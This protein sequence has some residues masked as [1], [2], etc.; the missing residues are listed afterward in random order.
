[1]KH[2]LV[3]TALC[4]AAFPAHAQVQVKDPWVRA[5]V[6]QQ[7]SSGAFMQI[8]SPAELRLVSVSSPVAGVVELHRMSMEN[9]IMKMRAVP[10]I[11]IPA[12]VPV[13]LKPGGYHVMMMALKSQLKEGELVPLTL[14]VEGRDGKRQTI[15]V[16]ARV[17][18]LTASPAAHDGGMHT[19][20]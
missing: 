14:I 5:T 6:P 7:N 17:R 18:A 11:E 19:K 10:G 1:M 20:H 16:K 4:L 12:G 9:D 3:A 13:E 2:L 8:S 15:E